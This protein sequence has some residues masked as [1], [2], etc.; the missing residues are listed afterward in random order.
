MKIIIQKRNYRYLYLV[1]LIILSCNSKVLACSC[2]TVKSFWEE[3]SLSND[4][5]LLVKII[6]I[7]DYHWGM[8][9]KVIE[10]HPQSNINDTLIIWG[11]NTL[12]C[13]Y[14]RTTEYKNGD[15][16]YYL[17][18]KTDLEGNSASQG[19][20][21]PKDIEKENDYMLANC[22]CN[23]LLIDNKTVFG[24]VS[25]NALEMPIDSFLNLIIE[26]Y[27]GINENFALSDNISVY[28]N[29]VSTSLMIRKT[30]D[31]NVLMRIY[32][33]NGKLVESTMLNKNDY[34]YHFQQDVHSKIFL[35]E[36]STDK[37][38]YV[39]KILKR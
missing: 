20:D 2:S 22:G 13:R 15:T 23:I 30:I 10:K 34:E 9:V 8:K 28:P 27:V 18:L 29:P 19:S 3:Y 16:L 36:F 14:A 39:K 38:K 7:E 21:F 11:I 33:I 4:E 24:Q 35:V 37:Y 26:P 17:L 6:K 1:L 12:S 31:E 25:D 32:D 5:M